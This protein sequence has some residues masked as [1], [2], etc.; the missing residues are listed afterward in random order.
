VIFDS[1]KG[2]FSPNFGSFLRILW[3]KNG[4]LKIEN[5]LFDHNFVLLDVICLEFDDPEGFLGTNENLKF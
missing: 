2:C 3:Q 5:P 1:L 4:V